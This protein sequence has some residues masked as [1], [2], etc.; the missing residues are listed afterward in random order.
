[1]L[2]DELGKQN[3][4]F[5]T[6]AVGLPHSDAPVPDIEGMLESTEEEKEDKKEDEEAE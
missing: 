1:M 6:N 4:D 2:A 3:P 5:A